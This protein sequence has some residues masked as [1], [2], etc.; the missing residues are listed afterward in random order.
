MPTK[1]AKP[2][3]AAEAHAPAFA[4]ALRVVGLLE[5]DPSLQLD[6]VRE[7]PGGLCGANASFEFRDAEGRAFTVIVAQTHAGGG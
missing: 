7:R 4:Y 3:P 1:K 6:A 5:S 2:P